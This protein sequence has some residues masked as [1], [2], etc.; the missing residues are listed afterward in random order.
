[1]IYLPLKPEHKEF[2]LLR[3]KARG[4]VSSESIPNDKNALICCELSPAFRDQ[5]PL[6]GALS[7]TWG[8]AN[9]TRPI[10]V[11]GEVINVTTNLKTALEH[12]QK[13]VTDVVI[14]I[15]AI[16]I[17]QTDTLE[18]NEQVQQMTDIYA[19][20]QQTIVWL[21]PA[22][23]GSDAMISECNR[24]GAELVKKPIPDLVGVESS[25]KSIADLMI[26]VANIPGDHP[27]DYQAMNSKLN[28]RLS[29]FFKRAQADIPGTLAF[30]T[31]TQ[32]LLERAY[33]NRVWIRQE[34]VV[35][36]NINIQCGLSTIMFAHL[37]ACLLYANFLKA[38][39]GLNIYTKLIDMM[40][41]SSEEI[42]TKIENWLERQG[43]EETD[44]II[45]EFK[46]LQDHLITISN[47]QPTPVS[48][49]GLVSMRRMYHD[50][51]GKPSL[52]LIRILTVVHVDGT[53]QSFDMRDRVFAML[54]MAS[55]QYE[56]S[57]D[58]PDYDPAKTYN[59]VYTQ[60]AK[61]IIKAGHVDLLSFAQNRPIQ[62]S[63]QTA[64]STPRQVPS[65]VP[66]WRLPMVRPCGQRPW[67]TFFCASGTKPFEPVSE[68]SQIAP[69]HIKLQGY[70]V[71][72]IECL[73][74]A[75]MPREDNY[76]RDF[77]MISQYL[78]DVFWLCGRSDAKLPP[79]G[80]N[81]YFKP[82][83]R[84]E[85]CQRI[86]VADQEQYGTGFIRKATQDTIRQLAELVKNISQH[87][88]IPLQSQQ[89]LLS[90]G[91]LAY[92]NMMSWQRFRKPFL[93]RKGYVGLV[94]DHSKVGDILV[95]FLGAKFPYVLRKNSHDDT[96]SFVG[97]AYVHGIMY[98]E[99]LK[100]ARDTRVFVLA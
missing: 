26:E 74:S 3:I 33:W 31:A 64:I 81:I 56:L 86:P 5:N 14:W 57:I 89:A 34:F 41:N 35:S 28:E 51:R 95:V 10:K 37:H 83:D 44:P 50:S 58:P 40:Q 55:D 15:D 24:I 29:G 45:R 22:K 4:I 100:R 82:S 13:D 43:P 48:T 98:G 17:N 76:S 68:F 20:A 63:L 71:D 25:D 70:F 23:D 32:K 12:I 66:D 93:S 69:N 73:G 54:Q 7:Y 2:R 11:N 1:M 47:L 53:T 92:L 77:S 46:G 59:I 36:S 52:S 42:S 90:S 16:C 75:W 60:A 99:F 84:A 65:W 9:D 72:N 27:D 85:A 61:A 88:N 8:D 80:E 94:P 67:E 87:G 97:E 18:K 19:K 6:Y 30:L 79:T 38:S 39:V 49:R 96:Y 21:G 62:E 78:I 91:P